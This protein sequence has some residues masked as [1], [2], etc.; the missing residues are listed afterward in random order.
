MLTPQRIVHAPVLFALTVGGA[1]AVPNIPGVQYAITSDGFFDLEEMPKR[2]VIV[3]AGYIAVEI[4]GVL[5]S[6]GS[7]MTA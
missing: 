5:N 3:G 7:G 2:T 6:F 1:P 4:G